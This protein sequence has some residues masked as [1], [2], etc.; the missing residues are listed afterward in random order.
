VREVKLSAKNQIF[1]AREVRAA[2]GV[3]AGDRLLVVPRGN[4]AILLRKP[5]KYA[6]AI[7]GLGKDIYEPNYLDKERESWR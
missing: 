6:K 5:K 1:V 4:A 2:L 7:A 3:K